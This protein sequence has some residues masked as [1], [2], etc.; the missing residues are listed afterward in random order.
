MRHLLEVGA[1]V[2]S[3][4][5]V[6]WADEPDL[7][8]NE[9]ACVWDTDLGV[10]VAAQPLYRAARGGDVEMVQ[11]LLQYRADPEVQASDGSTA[12][13]AACEYGHLS[14]AHLLYS[15]GVKTTTANR[16]GTTPLLVAAARNQLEIIRFLYACGAD[17]H[18]PGHYLFELHVDTECPCPV[19]V[20][21]T[22]NN[23]AKSGGGLR[24]L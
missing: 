2:N 20:W 4:S 1:Q 3:W 5:T 13:F 8:E 19:N 23:A 21:V 24:G 17:L 18:A 14:V 7:D 22:V 6:Y 16:M 9:D 11:L 15:L 12:L 10:P